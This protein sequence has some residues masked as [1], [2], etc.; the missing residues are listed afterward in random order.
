MAFN[1]QLAQRIRVA[2]KGQHGLEGKRMF[3]GIAF[4]LNGRMC[5]GVETVYNTG[6]CGRSTI[7]WQ[8]S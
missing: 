8:H 2:L 7:R 5:C 3:G 1:E 4:I 6:V